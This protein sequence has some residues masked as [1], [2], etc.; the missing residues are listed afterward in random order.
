MPIPIDAES[1]VSEELSE[2]I[3]VL[4][5]EA[6]TDEILTLGAVR[7]RLRETA[8]AADREPDRRSGS[9]ET[10]YAEVER[11]IDDYGED[12]PVADLVVVKASEDLSEL[13]EVLVDEGDEETVQTLADIRAAI[14]DGRAAQ[15][16]GIGVIEADDEQALV[17]ELDGL[18][19]RYGGDTPA[20]VVLRFD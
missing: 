4:L 10:L 3:E 17:A 2:V 19:E 14:V 6:G 7:E 11:L 8:A 1:L 20:E 12:A 18:I 16:E 9:E 13:I 15:L 5:E